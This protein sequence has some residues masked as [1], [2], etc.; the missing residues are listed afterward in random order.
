MHDTIR[1]ETD[2]V[3]PVRTRKWYRDLSPKHDNNGPCAI[4][5][6]K[7]DGHFV[8]EVKFYKTALMALRRR[9]NYCRFPQDYGTY[10]AWVPELTPLF[11][12]HLSW[13]TGHPIHSLANGMYWLAGMV[14]GLHE[15]YH[16]GD[17]GSGRSTPD[18]CA[19]AFA[20]HCRIDIPTAWQI[21]REVLAAKDSD[22]HEVWKKRHDS[23]VPKW[24]SEADYVLK[25]FFS[26]DED[27]D[28]QVRALEWD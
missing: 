25:H 17:G 15:T 18:Q 16:G 12:L 26:D 22:Y 7:V 5:V 24:R 28:P 9:G 2:E 13:F 6:G 20:S 11:N 8:V 3:S 21:A 23:L 4:I 14:G 19:Q 27:R 10:R 1:L